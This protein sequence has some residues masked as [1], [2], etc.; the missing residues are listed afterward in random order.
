MLTQQSLKKRFNQLAKVFDAIVNFTFWVAAV[1]ILFLALIVGYEV[2]MRHIFNAPTFWVLQTAGYCLAF[3][4]FFSVT[5]ILQ[6]D[7]HTRM[8]VVLDILPVHLVNSINRVTALL[9][10]I[11]C[12]AM[13]WR[14]GLSTYEGYEWGL[15]I[16]EGYRIP[17]YYVWWVMPFGFGCLT[18]QFL[19]MVLG[20]KP[21]RP[22]DS[23]ES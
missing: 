22:M 3:I 6:E 23:V 13:T 1:L 11:V 20:Y 18:I 9:A 5:K 12:A 14:T 4:T 10:A 15:V 17:Q 7:G 2:I 21:Q 8:T 19:R 16:W